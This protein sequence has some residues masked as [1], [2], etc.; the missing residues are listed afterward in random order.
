MDIPHFVTKPFIYMYM[1]TVSICQEDTKQWTY[2]RNSLIPESLKEPLMRENFIFLEFT[3]ARAWRIIEHMLKIYLT[4]RK[5][6]KIKTEKFLGG[7]ER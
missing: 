1:Y 4:T 5:T 2:L 3:A 7:R 6:S